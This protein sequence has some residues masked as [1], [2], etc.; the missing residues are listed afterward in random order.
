MFA[1]LIPSAIPNSIWVAN[2]TAIPQLAQLTIAVGAGGSHIPVMTGRDGSFEIL[3]R[4]VVFT[5]KVPTL[6]T[7]GDIILA[8]FSQYIVGLRSDFSLAKSQHVYFASDQA[9]YRGLLRCDGQ[10]KL[11]SPITPAYGD[12]LSPFVTLATRS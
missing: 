7:V 2:S 5:E 3:T 4:P 8:D 6:G 10:Q 12:T 1:R 9:A 11:N